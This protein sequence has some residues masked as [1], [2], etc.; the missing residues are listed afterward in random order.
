MNDKRKRQQDAGSWYRF[1]FEGLDSYY[2]QLIKELD[3][4]M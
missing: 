3:K 4:S 1:F 2:S